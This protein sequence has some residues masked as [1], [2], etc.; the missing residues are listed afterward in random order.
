MRRDGSTHQGGI[1]EHDLVLV[2]LQLAVV[3]RGSVKVGDGEV[4]PAGCRRRAGPQ[5]GGGYSLIL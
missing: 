5:L 1:A 3:G 2:E 4:G